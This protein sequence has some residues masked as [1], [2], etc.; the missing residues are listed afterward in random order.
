MRLR[1]L[2]ARTAAAASAVLL[3]A[4]ASLTTASGAP[5]AGGPAFSAAPLATWQTNGTVWSI[6]SAHGVVYVGGTFDKVRPP[7]ARPGEKEVERRSFAAFDA[8]SGELLPCTH[9]FNGGEAT[10]RAMKAS[11]D[12]KVLYV[13]GSFG[14]VDGKG[15]A[16][17]VAID[18][19]GCTLRDDFR[20]EVAAIVRAVDVTKDTVYLGGDF[21]RVDGR[22][23]SHIAAFTR[24]GR[25][26]PFQ[27]TLDQ[28]VRAVLAAPDYGK[29]LVGGDFD[30]A[31]GAPQHALVALDPATGATVFSY[32]GW[33]PP[34]SRVKA[35]A[36]EGSVFYLGAEGEGGGAFD[37]RLANPLADDRML[38]RDFCYGATQA[39]VP[40]K[41]V[42]YSAAHAHDC[43]QTPGG[44]PEHGKMWH[45][46]AQSATDETLFHWYPDTDGGLG[47]GVG[48]RALGVAAG[49][50]WAGGE[51]TRV[52]GVPQQSLTR[53]AATGD[54]PVEEPPA[55]SLDGVRDGRVTFGW[56]ATWDRD[57]A[58]LTYSVYRDG[59]RVGSMKRRSAPW[60]RPWMTYTDT[61]APGSR[62]RYTVTV[63]D[64]TGAT[65]KSRPLT[66]TAA[67]GT[68]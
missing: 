45:L 53:F 52:N 56:W 40:Y 44:F 17:T 43:S 57:D 16:N 22:R 7:G 60:D 30:T 47:E 4:T 27:A 19:A 62:H 20:P 58:V 9:F 29:V 25:L 48:P 11:P 34:R 50:L 59:K 55:L 33:I 18:T 8:V 64:G 10:V 35:L 37:G 23:R 63:G 67:A 26:L 66:V 2:T 36:R 13:G 46:L 42:L 51:F 3:L 12:G 61:V 65:V 15:V 32:P 14:K 24:A 31:N 21:T 49:V 28:P 54:A 39:V 6:A 38:W 41:G 5:R 68:R 1:R